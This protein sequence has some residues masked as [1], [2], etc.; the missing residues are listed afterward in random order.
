MNNRNGA[1]AADI[2]RKKGIQ[3]VGYRS[4]GANA[5]YG[6]QR[7]MAVK[8]KQQATQGLMNVV[9][10]M[11]NMV[12]QQKY[13]KKR[14]KITMY[15]A[16]NKIGT[17]HVPSGLGLPADKYPGFAAPKY[18]G[19]YARNLVNRRTHRR[20]YK[21]DEP[22]ELFGS[23]PSVN[24]VGLSSPELATLRNDA[25]KRGGHHAMRSNDNIAIDAYKLAGQ[26]ANVTT[27]D[28]N[29]FKQSGSGISSQHHH[30][31]DDGNS[32]S[33][34]SSDGEDFA[35]EQRNPNFM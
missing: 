23:P 32:S 1:S 24:D 14:D 11:G 3:H 18:S 13:N 10:E 35:V 4:G 22:S 5:P 34:F 29:P 19:N 9:R 28:I 25:I 30:H 6:I 20:N 8:A 12:A 16:L 27:S 31:H 15:G 33:S 7:M 26:S 21:F 2:S 17:N